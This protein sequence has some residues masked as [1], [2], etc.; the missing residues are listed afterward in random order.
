MNLLEMANTIGG[1]L[2]PREMDALLATGEQQSAALLALTLNKMG[3]N[4]ISLTG[5][6]AGV[7]SDTNYSK[8]KNCGIDTERIKR[9]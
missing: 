5:W 2:N 9:N 6:Q 7:K 4:A 8:A 3:C 1:K